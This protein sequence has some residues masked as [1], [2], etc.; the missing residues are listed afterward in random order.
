[1]STKKQLAFIIFPGISAVLKALDNAAGAIVAS[2]TEQTGAELLV[3]YFG[4]AKSKVST[5]LRV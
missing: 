3:A 1:M 5:R 2:L 4:T